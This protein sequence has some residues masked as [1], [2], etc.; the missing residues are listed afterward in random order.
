[1]FTGYTFAI[2]LT[3]TSCLASVNM[4][5]RTT[6][7]NVI[8]LGNQYSRYK[9]KNQGKDVREIPYIHFI[10]NQKYRTGEVDLEQF[11]LRQGEKLISFN[12]EKRLTGN[13]SV[14][15]RCNH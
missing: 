10:D 11:L 8:P 13:H 15:V 9:K 4:P 6:I 14:T 5:S 1:M 3:Y 2:C 7:C 12:R